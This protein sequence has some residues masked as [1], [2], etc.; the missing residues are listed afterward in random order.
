MTLKKRSKKSSGRGG[1]RDSKSPPRSAVLP[2]I[3]VKGSE[4]EWPGPG[5]SLIV[6]NVTGYKHLFKDAYGAE[7]AIKRL[8]Q[9]DAMMMRVKK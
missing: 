2:Y 1:N 3:I 8:L 6:S 7:D 4:G 5:M 9:Y